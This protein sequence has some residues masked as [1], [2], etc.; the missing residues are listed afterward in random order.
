MPDYV[1][2]GLSAGLIWGIWAFYVNHDEAIYDGIKAGGIQFILSFIT[3]SSLTKITDF[4]FNSMSSFKFVLAITIATPI[5]FLFL[6]QIT[7]HWI[8][9]T[10][11]IPLTVAPVMLMGTSWVTFYSMKLVGESK[12][13]FEKLNGKK[14]E[15]E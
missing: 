11:N 2:S 15:N 4:I 14:F 7:V 8:S 5:I 1:F 10:P 6:F 9:S 12:I 13:G 3:G